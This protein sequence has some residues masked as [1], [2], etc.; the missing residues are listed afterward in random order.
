MLIWCLDIFPIQL[1]R[2][3][4]VLGHLYQRLRGD[5]V[6]LRNMLEERVQQWA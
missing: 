6:A 3:F 4:M 5:A 2:P 1:N